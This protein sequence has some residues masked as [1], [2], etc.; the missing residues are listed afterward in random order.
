M[1]SRMSSAMWSQR[2]QRSAESNIS[3]QGQ[4]R[5]M[6]VAAILDGQMSVDT[7]LPSSRE[8]RVLATSSG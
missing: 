6:L 4:I 2:F 5:Q 7:A 8:R 3:L 1:A